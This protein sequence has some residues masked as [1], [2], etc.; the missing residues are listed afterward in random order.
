LEE[1]LRKAKIA[2]VS[3]FV[4]KIELQ[5]G[6]VMDVPEFLKGLEKDMAQRKAGL[7]AL[8]SKS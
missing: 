3:R 2:N 8:R 1:K 6:I 4:N 7:N 5:K